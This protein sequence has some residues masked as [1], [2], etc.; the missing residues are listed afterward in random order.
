MKSC[1]LARIASLVP[2]FGDLSREDKVKTLLC[3][4]TNIAAKSINKF[5]GLMFKAREKIDEGA[6]PAQLTFP[7]Q[8]FL[9]DFDESD[10]D[11]EEEGGY[12]LASSSEN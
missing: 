4:A 3:P 12:D 6:D 2:N 7:P 8:V 1:L 10:T 11:S 9:Q 5:I